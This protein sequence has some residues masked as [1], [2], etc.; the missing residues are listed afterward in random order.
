VK[1]VS[2]EI[3]SSLVILA[4]LGRTAP[5]T[6]QQPQSTKPPTKTDWFPASPVGSQSGSAPPGSQMQVE[7]MPLVAPVFFEDGQT[8]SSLV[9]ANSTVMPAG[10]TIT[11]RSL[12]GSDVVTVH[13]KLAPHE[14][15]EIALQS[16]LIHSANPI[17]AGSITV[18]Q[19]SNLKGMAVAAQLL[20]TKSISSFLRM[21]TKSLPCPA[22]AARQSSGGWP[23]KRLDPHS[24][25]S[26]AS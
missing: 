3:L 6:A 18:T 11:V 15:Q 19:D 10:A 21:L 12:A 8:T 13:R 22:L 17:S 4:T 20:L 14:Q 23:T 16:L 7:P 25:L 2:S 26:Q 5:L 1:F 24:L 9:I